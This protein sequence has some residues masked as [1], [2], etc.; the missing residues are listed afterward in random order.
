MVSAYNINNLNASAF[1]IATGKH[2][3][4]K[5]EKVS[6]RL[7]GKL[8]FRFFY[9]LD[10]TSISPR[11]MQKPTFFYSAF[12]YNI[13]GIF[14]EKI[15]LKIFIR[16]YQNSRVQRK[17]QRLVGLLEFR[18]SYAQHRRLREIM[19]IHQMTMIITPRL[20]QVLQRLIYFSKKVW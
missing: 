5:S 8:F 3:Q 16:R 6:D 7:E 15:V 14:G 2:V 11:I 10:S 20:L 1:L 17:S 13:T 19:M 18:S 4:L 9:N 12:A